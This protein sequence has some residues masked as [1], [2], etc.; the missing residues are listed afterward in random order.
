MAGLGLAQL[1][2]KE[3]SSLEA[4]TGTRLTPLVGDYT[5]SCSV[6]GQIRIAVDLDGI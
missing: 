4:P 1:K 6:E 3:K 2:N 5:I